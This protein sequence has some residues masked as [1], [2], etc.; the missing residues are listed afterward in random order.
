MGV[1]AVVREY[2]KPGCGVWSIDVM[3]GPSP[4]RIESGSLMQALREQD[5]PGHLH[6]KD[7]VVYAQPDGSTHLL[8]CSHPYS[9]SCA[10]TGLAVRDRGA[11]GFRLV[12]RQLVARGPVWDVASTRVTCRFSLPRLGRF[13]SL[14]P[15]SILFYD[16]LECVRQHEENRRAVSRPR[17]YSCE[18]LSGAMVGFDAEFPRFER[19]SY[20]APLFI[21]PYGTGCSRYVDVVNTKEGLLA[22][23][24]QSQ[25][26]LSQP[27]VGH[28]LL[29]AEVERLLS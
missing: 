13:A 26:D 8:F 12:T 23:W 2:L 16:G 4:D 3:T 5:D 22:T 21:S 11:D 19:L 9:W 29:L 24:Q 25:T 1:P 10:N 28:R 7:P 14:P 20:L 15:L 17:G 27:L 18:E 6:V